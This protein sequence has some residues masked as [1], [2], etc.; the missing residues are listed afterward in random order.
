M[1]KNA[2]DQ[3]LPEIAK[4]LVAPSFFWVLHPERESVGIRLGPGG[5]LSI[6]P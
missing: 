5:G 1:S 2:H 3:T 4:T 6:L